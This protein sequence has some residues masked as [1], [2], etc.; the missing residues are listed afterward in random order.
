[1]GLFKSKEEKAIEQRIL[2][3]RTISMM[4]K[5]INQL[6]SQKQK[7]IEA[8]KKA[9]L[10][11]STAQYNLAVSGLKTALAQQK[12]AEEMILNFE[13]TSQLRDLTK[14]TS[15]FLDG[16]RVISQEMS[17]ITKNTDFVKVQ[18]E[19]EQAMVGAETQSERLDVFLEMSDD[20]FQN[21]A[22]DSSKIDDEEIA[23]LID[24]ES[25]E[26]EDGMDADIEQKLAEVKKAITN[27]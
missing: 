25:S 22:A 3:K 12:K 13:L 10:Q 9:K 24:V 1:M 20:S 15:E 26:V 23:R 4:N 6:E 5:H 7:Y 8:A 21:I 14:M 11:G 17:A 19:F 16:M 2:I 27:N 18:K